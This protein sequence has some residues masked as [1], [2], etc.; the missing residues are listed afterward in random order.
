MSVMEELAKVL[1][2]ALCERP[3]SLQA[4]VDLLEK[5]APTPQERE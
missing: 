2:K 5:E 3:A 1:K 4:A